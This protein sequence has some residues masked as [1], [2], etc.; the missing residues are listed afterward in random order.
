MLPE[1]KRASD[2]DRLDEPKRVD[3]PPKKGRLQALRFRLQLAVLRY[4][5]QAAMVIALFV[6]LVPVYMLVESNAQLRAD[7]SALRDSNRRVSS[8]LVYIQESRRIITQQFC[9]VINENSTSTNAQNDYLQQILL[10]SVR[11]SRPLDD[12]LKSVPGLPSFEERR[13]RARDQA[14]GLEEFKVPQINC[15]VLFDTIN[16]QVEALQKAEDPGKCLAL[17]R[18]P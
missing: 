5:I 10:D 6:L 4:P 7:A 11:R 3:D 12:L 1:G 17:A 18:K 13:R 15:V 2:P 9:G 8:S 14:A 16:C